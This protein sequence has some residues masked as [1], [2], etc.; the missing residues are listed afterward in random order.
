[1]P[2]PNLSSEGSEW[3]EDEEDENEHGNKDIVSSPTG[4]HYNISQLSS[5]TQQVVRGLFHQTFAPGPPQISLELCGIKE[6]ED[7]EDGMFYAFQMHE[8]VPCSVRIGSRKSKRFSTPK[9]ECSDARYR[10]L[11]P[12]KHII[13]LFDRISQQFLFDRDPESQL[14]LTEHGYPE[15]LSD[16]FERISETRLDVLANSLHCDTADAGNDSAYPDSARVKEAREIV[17]TLAGIKPWELDRYRPDLDSV[18][19]RNVVLRYGDLEATLFS[20]LL[21]SHSL[22]EWVRSQ[23]RPSDPPIDPFRGIQQQVSRIIS[24]LQQYSTSL[25]GESASSIR[26]QHRKTAEDPRDVAWAATQIQQSVRKI[27]KLISRGSAPLSEPLRASAARSLVGI[28]KSV[29]NQNIDLYPGDT[30]DDR[31]LYMRL[32][33][34][35]DTGFVYSALELLVDQSQFIEELEDIMDQLGRYGAPATY[36]S[37]MR[38]LMARMR[39]YNARDGD[40]SSPHSIPRAETPPIPAYEVRPMPDLEAEPTRHPQTPVSSDSPQFLT[41]ELPASSMTRAGRGSRGR[42]RGR[43]N[44]RASGSSAGSKRSVSLGSSQDTARGSKRRAR[45]F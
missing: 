33:G 38:E 26:L 14:T 32:V 35:H 24:D 17:A 13:W 39:H 10:N 31:N 44:T 29:V 42:P 45:G 25:R 12:C 21:N 20:L 4:L 11:R 7:E 9:C 27:E 16:V 43:G 23:L 15:E 19:D 3:E 18:Y 30:S 28:L 36:V 2:D 1:M 41:P 5:K 22:S 6:D 8:V 34:N 40:V 37:N